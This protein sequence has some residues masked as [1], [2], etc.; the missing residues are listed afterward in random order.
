MADQYPPDYDSDVGR[1]RKY[2]PDIALLDNPQDP[3]DAPSY[4]WGDNAIQSFI[5]DQERFDVDNMPLDPQPQPVI[6]RAASEILIATAN[7]E[8]LVMKKI[9]TEDLQTDGPS[10]SRALLQAADALRR[11][12]KEIDDDES[13][14][15]VFLIV[16]YL[17]TPPRFDWR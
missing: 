17:H 1:V 6:L 8:V 3:T 15:S 4:M 2:I 10:V 7:N 14:E 12:A 16:D 13:Q 11:R 9:V 5:N